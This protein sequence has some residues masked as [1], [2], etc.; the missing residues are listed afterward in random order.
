MSNLLNICGII[1]A[2]SR[3]PDATL[4]ILAAILSL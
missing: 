3:Y 1:I 4:Q 2:S